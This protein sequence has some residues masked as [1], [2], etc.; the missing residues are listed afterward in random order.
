MPIVD[1]FP[2][3]A[4][5]F[6]QNGL[7]FSFSGQEGFC[8]P[9][10]SEVEKMTDTQ[11]KDI[12]E[13]RSRGMSYAAIADALGVPKSTVTT[14]CQRNNLSGR[15]GASIHSKDFCPQCGRKVVQIPGRKPRRF[16]SASCRQT[17]WNSHL[18]L[19][20]H[21]EI[22]IVSCEHCGATFEVFGASVQRFCSHDCYIAERFHAGDVS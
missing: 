7:L 5:F 22:R 13:S 8:L 15:R 20:K 1:F 14:F 3:W 10:T 9:K 4:N 17:W 18:S 6:R 12:A 2:R 11:K 19:V 16:C 21:K